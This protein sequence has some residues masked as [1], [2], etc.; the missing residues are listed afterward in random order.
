M[1]IYKTKL[2]RMT[3]TVRVP[4]HSHILSIQIQDGEPTMWY[5][6]EQ[7]E[8]ETEDWKISCLPTGQTV[9]LKFEEFRQYIAT[10]QDGMPVITSLKN[11]PLQF[12]GMEF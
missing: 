2:N 3:L 1:I 7:A 5:A 10:V 9:W 4:R 8:I 11:K 12:P 6:F